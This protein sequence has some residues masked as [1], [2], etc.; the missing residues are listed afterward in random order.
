MNLVLM[1][2]RQK[3]TIFLDADENASLREL[4]VMITGTTKVGPENQMV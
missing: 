1:L 2:K 4:N 3:E